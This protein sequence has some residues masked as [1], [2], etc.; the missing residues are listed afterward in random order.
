M[1]AVKLFLIAIFVLGGVS[2][3]GYR[4]IAVTGKEAASPLDAPATVQ[5]TDSIYNNKV[6]VYWDAVRGATSYRIFKN[7]TNDPSTATDIGTT[8]ASFFFD[9]SSIPGQPSF[10]WVRAENAN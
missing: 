9:L 6:G 8:A 10:Y 2:F 7:S 3:L 5:A 1:R 4:P